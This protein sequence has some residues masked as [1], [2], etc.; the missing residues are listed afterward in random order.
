M[1]ETRRRGGRAARKALHEAPTP[2]DERAVRPGH[3]GGRY[4]PL[5]EADVAQIH[6]AVL[7]VLE[8]IGLVNA[9]PT[10]IDLVTN[11]GGTLTDEG[12]LLFPRALVEDTIANAARDITLYGQDPKHDMLRPGRGLGR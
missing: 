8:T 1:A 6:E 7:D 2:E 5:T 11:A 10:C 9:L 12:R 3:A 4:Q